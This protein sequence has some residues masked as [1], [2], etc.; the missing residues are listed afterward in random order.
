MTAVVALTELLYALA[1]KGS[2]RAS[3]LRLRRTT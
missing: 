1:D 2:A 3:R